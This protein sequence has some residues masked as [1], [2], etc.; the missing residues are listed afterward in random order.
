MNN[1]T[2]VG[3]T[4][5]PIKLLTSQTGKS[6]CRFTLACKN[7]FRDEEDKPKTDF[8]TCVAWNAKAK[9]LDSYAFKG[10][11]LC[12]TGAMISRNYQDEKGQ[13]KLIW[14]VRVEDV[15]FLTTKAEREKLKED[16]LAEEPVDDSDLPF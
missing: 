11:L 10:D 4:T 6:Y 1:I 12:V 15:E 3:R 9:L 5:K 7:K 16:E 2:I 13:D 14:E 8:F